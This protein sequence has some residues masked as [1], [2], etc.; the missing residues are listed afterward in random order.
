MRDP[1]F[2]GDRDAEVELVTSNPTIFQVTFLRGPIVALQY[3]GERK[4]QA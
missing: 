2:E 4:T 3:H 1:K